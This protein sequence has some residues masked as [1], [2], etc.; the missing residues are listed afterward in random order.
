MDADKPITNKPTDEECYVRGLYMEGASWDSKFFYFLLILILIV[1]FQAMQERLLNLNCKYCTHLC[2]LCVSIL[3]S[4]VPC[5]LPC[6]SSLVLFP[7]QPQ[8][9]PLLPPLLLLSLIY[10]LYTKH[11]QEEVAQTILFAV[12]NCLRIYPM[13][14]GSNVVFV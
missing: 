8:L 10:V 14:T 13:S 11:W 3:S 5:H 9:L 4:T 12:S 1:L 6:L 2:L 7:P